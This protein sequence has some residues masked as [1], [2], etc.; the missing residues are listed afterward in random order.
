V[1]ITSRLPSN[2]LFDPETIR[3]LTGAFEDA[4]RSLDG[5]DWIRPDADAI[6][7]M[8][9]K[10]II[11]AAQTGERD[12]SRLRDGAVAYVTDALERIEAIRPSSTTRTPAPMAHSSPRC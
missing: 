9:A 12:I 8:L 3:T 5:G 10:H 6:R 7:E 11:T 2:G 4:W 1:P